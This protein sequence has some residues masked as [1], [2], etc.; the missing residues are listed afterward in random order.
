MVR[1]CAWIVV[2][3]FAVLPLGACGR[4]DAN[5]E[6]PAE[7][8]ARIVAMSPAIA[9]ML[10]DLG[11]GERIVGRHG[12]D[13]W[14]D[15]DVPVCGDQAGVDVEMLLAVAPTHVLFEGDAPAAVVRLGEKHGWV[16]RSW[17]LLTLDEVRGGLLDLCALFEGEIEAGR[18]EE[19]VGAFDRAMS[20]RGGE[21]ANAEGAEG[22]A[23]SAGKD[24]GDSRRG[25][26]LLMGVEPPTAL[27]PGSFHHQILER[28]GGGATGAA[29]EEGGPYMV[30]SAEDVLALDPDGIILFQPR[31][32]G[33]AP[34]SSGLSDPAAALGALAALD[35]AA[36]RNGRVAVID[37]PLG[38]VPGTNL[39]RLADEMA[40]TLLRWEQ[41]AKLRDE[42]R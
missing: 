7:E 23:E 36:A 30:L 14:T 16:V 28:L 38:F 25:V 27:G 29:I 41:T 21:E 11:L 17:R 10:R 39:I 6:R 24:E 35:L 3:A 5:N 20:A 8:E 2:V 40:E 37:D 13:A 9:V 12:F 19:L 22:S 15:Q 1:V 4:G 42:S 18:C 32:P 33:A 26:L 31:A 34:A